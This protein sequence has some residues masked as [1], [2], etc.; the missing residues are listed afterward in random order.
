MRVSEFLDVFMVF[1]RAQERN[2]VL[3]AG[4]ISGQLGIP[5]GLASNRIWLT[6]LGFPCAHF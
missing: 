3:R 6:I 1:Q 5:A 4:A 2:T